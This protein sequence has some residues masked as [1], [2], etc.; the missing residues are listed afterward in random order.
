MKLGRCP[1]CQFDSSGHPPTAAPQIERDARP[2]RA[3]YTVSSPSATSS[4]DLSPWG[5][6]WSGLGIAFVGAV[7]I[8]AT[9]R[10]GGMLLGLLLAAIG[11][12]LSTIGTIALGVRIGISAWQ[13]STATVIE[14][15]RSG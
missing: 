11:A 10:D 13:R 4:D 8:D 12:L 1:R 7:I 3:A 5:Y 6:V 15:S 14:V 2:A 9:S